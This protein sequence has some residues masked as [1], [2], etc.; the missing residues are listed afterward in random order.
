MGMLIVA[1]LATGVG[2]LLILLIGRGQPVGPASPTNLAGEGEGEL[3][4]VRG[5]G[6]EGFQRLLLT[7]FTE[8]GFNPERSERGTRTVD[9]FA[10]DPTPIRG[11]R[12]YVHGL[13]GAPGV[14]TEADEV[15][16][17]IETARSEIL[18]KRVRVTMGTL[19]SY[20]RDSARGS[21]SD[22]LAGL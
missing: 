7:L 14:P 11:G 12:L 5:Y 1:A 19:S 6:I 2:F 16:N 18:R 17:M 4:W 3:S 10:N 9:L 13:F 8:M 21:P 15:R 22:L 20:A